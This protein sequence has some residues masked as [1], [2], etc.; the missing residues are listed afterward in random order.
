MRWHA[1][2]V[3]LRPASHFRTP[4]AGSVAAILGALLMGLCCL[5]LLLFSREFADSNSELWTTRIVG[6][7]GALLRGGGSVLALMRGAG[8][9]WR[10][11]LTPSGVYVRHGSARS[12]T[13]WDSIASVDAFETTVYTKG[14][15]VH[16]PFV[17]ITATDPAAIK[18]DSVDQAIRLLVSSN[19]DTIT[20]PIRTLGVD[21]KLLLYALSYYHARPEARPELGQ[22]AGLA[23]INAGDLR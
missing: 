20:L 17:P 10:V 9:G 5:G 3:S 4:R 12:V 2:T 14:G 15:A 21:P 22:A 18:G 13:R 1:S 6:G 7:F 16:E 19:A 11:V 23:R 8:R